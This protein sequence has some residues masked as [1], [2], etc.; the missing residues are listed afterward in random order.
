MRTRVVVLISLAVALVFLACRSAEVTAARV[1]VQQNDF[2]AALEQL[3]IA[4][5]KEPMNPEVFIMMG[6]IYAEMDSFAQMAEAFNRALEIDSTEIRE[7]DA[8]RIDKRAEAFRRGQRA[9]E[10]QRWQEAIEHTKTAVLIDP[11]FV[12]GWYNLGFFYQKIDDVENSRDAYYKAYELDPK[13]ILLAKQAAVFKFNEGNLDEAIE[14]LDAVVQAGD[15]DLE[16]YTLLGNLYVAKG[17]AAKADEMLD[18][19]EKL[20][21]D[22]PDLLFD[23]G[24]ARY[25]QKD[26]DGAIEYF[27]RIIASDPT[28][29]DALYNLSLSQFS[30]ERYNEAAATAEKLVKN[31]PQDLPGWEQFA[32]SLL[33]AEQVNK[34]KDAYLVS[35][36]IQI[37]AEGDYATAVTNL[38]AVTAKNPSWCAAWSLL[39]VSC[40]ETGEDDC[41]QMAQEGLN[42]CGN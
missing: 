15:A 17:D 37:M 11:T 20:A 34:G 40:N 16:T 7:I 24:V 33:R 35:E 9:G 38:K 36:T 41:V 12:D 2:P 42:N 22:N 32:L 13:N 25:N 18:S 3:K 29:R 31:N 30:A 21:P 10:S 28:N 19:A 4:E 5:E 27:E 26:F 14:I 8:W 39:L 23:R 1:Y 6:K